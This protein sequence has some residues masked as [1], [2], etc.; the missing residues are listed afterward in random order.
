MRDGQY[1]IEEFERFAKG[2]KKASDI[3]KSNNPD[4]I[5]APLSGSVPFIDM[6]Y[7][8]DRH[9]DLGKVEYPPNS[10]RFKDREG[11]ISKWYGN[12]LNKNYH[13]KPIKIF[14]IDEVVSGSS[15]IKGYDEF[16]K[17]LY[18]F[19]K[20]SG[21]SLDQKIS[22]KIIGI[23]EPQKN[24]ERKNH[25]LK[26]LVNSKKIHLIDVG[27]I[28]TMDNLELNHVRFKIE[29]DNSQGRHIY[30]PE[31]EKFYVSSS[32]VSLLQNFASYIGADPSKVTVQNLGK[33]KESLEK[34]L[35]PEIVA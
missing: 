8:L 18:N 26:E 27:K 32:Y 19:K 33:I 2:I 5:F 10:S 28:I 14:C 34:Y 17:A 11:I 31:I 1:S 13:V 20:R 30:L 23:S 7:I 35:H 16:Q 29:R 22:Y 24:G 9:F 12:F 3:L 15:A 4:Y 25:V 21:E 6:F